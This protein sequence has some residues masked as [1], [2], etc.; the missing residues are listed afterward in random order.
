MGVAQSQPTKNNVQQEKYDLAKEEASI[1]KNIDALMKRRDTLTSST[2]GTINFTDVPAINLTDD[3]PT[4]T[5]GTK[6]VSARQRYAKYNVNIVDQH[7]GLNTD[8]AN[9]TEMFAATEQALVEN[10]DV[11]IANNEQPPVE[12]SELSFSALKQQLENEIDKVVLMGGG[13][14][15]DAN[16]DSAQIGGKKNNYSSTSAYDSDLNPGSKSEPGSEPESEPKSGS[17]SGSEIGSDSVSKSDSGPGSDSGSTQKNKNKEQSLGNEYSLTA[18]SVSSINLVPF[19]STPESSF[20]NNV[21]QR[22]RFH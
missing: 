10:A 12:N 8:F 16:D 6:F 11:V 18:T 22:K 2:S 21:Q 19:Y 1:M 14:G 17:N 20:N 13:C 4:H 15:C 5:G 7:G 9:S 3:V